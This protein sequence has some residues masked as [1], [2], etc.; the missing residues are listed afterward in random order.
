MMKVLRR[1]QALRKALDPYRN[2][3]IGLVPTMGA[4]HEGHLS[5]LRLAKKENDIT[6]ASIFVN[7]LQF[8]PK[9]DLRRYPRNFL[10]D[11]KLLI[12]EKTDFLFAPSKKTFY[13]TDF[14][15]SVSV[16][17]LSEPL[18]GASRPGHFAGVATVVLKLL[19]LV[20]PTALYLGQKDYQQFRVVTQMVKDLDIP[21]EVRRAP[22]FR[23]PDG[24]AMSSRNVFLSETERKEALCLVRALKL[25]RS[26]TAKG[27]KDCR[28]IRREML[29]VI[30]KAP[31]ARLDYAEIVDAATLEPV[32][33]LTKGRKALAA[34]AVFFSK[35]R[36]ID[37]VLIK[38]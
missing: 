7:P 4:L 17:C 9:E 1:S 16:K 6:V 32:V 27:V 11:K 15:T 2:K 10:R 19:N 36:L 37:N 33:K 23:E 3:K 8:G 13:L 28:R 18:C 31:H 25:A 35:T 21:V 22:I 14:Q 34:L 30:K 5:L 29:A 12:K 20:R 24:L 26:L 38:G